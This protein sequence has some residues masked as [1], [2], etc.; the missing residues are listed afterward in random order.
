M[1]HS[2]Y[3]IGAGG[4]VN[5]A[6]LPAYALS[7]FHVGGIY[8]IHEDRARATANKF[9]IST[10]F[11]TLDSL[12]DQA[13]PNTVFD[14]AVPATSV[15]DVLKKL[16]VRSNVLIQKPMGSNLEDAFEIL[17]LTRTKQQTAAINFQLRY[18]PS[19]LQA[20]KMIGEG[21]IG[22]LCDIEVN[23]NV[24]T[25]WHLWTFLYE[26]SRVEILYHSIHYIDL[27]RSF[28]GNPQSVYAKTLKHPDMPQLASVR[29]T[30]IMDYGEILRAMIHTNHTHSFGDKH[31]HAYI[32]LEGT[33]GA[34]RIS[35][36][37]LKNYPLD[38]ADQFEY[39]CQDERGRGNWE[40]LKIEG[41]WF[42]HAF[43]ESMRE[44]MIAI[45]QG[46]RPGHSVEDSIYTMAC[47]EAAYQSSEAGGVRLPV[48]SRQKK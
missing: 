15:L 9:D 44:L 1:D 7:R 5:D 19:I 16:P 14:V 31:Q 41:S 26:A 6:H 23:V 32:K 22:T 13:R 37:I 10:I 46:R 21:I 2:I 43:A 4:I 36:R 42:P 29:S 45:D 30:I 3:I 34:I 17:E 18:A 39:V 28:C 11:G 33:K 38:E 48:F 35:L 25:P 40:S 20:R 27:I 12:I 24:Y 8:D 47:V